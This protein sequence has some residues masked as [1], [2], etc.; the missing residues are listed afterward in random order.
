MNIAS[1]E[2]IRLLYREEQYKC[3]K[4]APRLIAK[5]AGRHL[6]DVIMLTLL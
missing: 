1:F 4:L 5:A 3:A 2:D 6:S